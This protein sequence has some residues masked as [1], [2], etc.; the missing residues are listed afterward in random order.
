MNKS[1]VLWIIPLFY[2]WYFN[3][4]FVIP[5]EGRLVLRLYINSSPWVCFVLATA[6]RTLGLVKKKVLRY[7]LKIFGSVPKMVV[8][9]WLCVRGAFDSCGRS[10]FAELTVAYITADGHCSHRR[11]PVSND[12]WKLVTEYEVNSNGESLLF[13]LLTIFSGLF[14][15]IYADGKVLFLIAAFKYLFRGLASCMWWCVMLGCK[16]SFEL[17]Y[18]EQDPLWCKNSD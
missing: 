3:N 1:I 10:R 7:K 14:V 17:P 11:G 18:S 4:E 12:L 8:L 16:E 13:M 6:S 2:G 15:D 9:V 5:L